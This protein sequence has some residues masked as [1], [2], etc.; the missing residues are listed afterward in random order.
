MS[1]V[2]TRGVAPALGF[3]DVMLTGLAPDGGLYVP[4]AWPE[5]TGSE[6]AGL[7][8]LSYPTLVA[9]ISAPFM[10]GAVAD[11]SGIAEEAY[12]PFERLVPLTELGHG[13]WLLELFWGPTLAFKDYA[14]QLL[15][16]LLDASLAARDSRALLLGATSGDTGSAAIEACRDRS[17]LDI[18]VLHPHG[19]VSDVQR[20]QMTTVA[21]ANVHNVAVRGTFDDCQRLV[22]AMLA[23]S[24]LRR[25]LGVT[26]VNSINWV[27][28]MAQ[29]AYYF[30]AALALGAP[31]REVSFAV[32]TGNF[33]NVFAAYVARQMG[34]PIRRLIIGTN[35]NNVVARFAETGRLS[36]ETVVP[37]ITPAMDI[38]VPS[39]LE[40]LLFDVHDQDG[41]AIRRLMS[42]FAEHGQLDLDPA[43][44]RQLQTFVTGRWFDEPAIRQTMADVFRENALLIDPHSAVGIAAARATER[45]PDIPV[46]C[47]GTAHPAKFPD[48]VEAAT[49]V[50]PPLPEHLAD[51]MERKEIMTVL[52]PDRSAIEAFVHGISR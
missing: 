6:I 28:I 47:V 5:F 22:K 43:R 35:R 29:V 27:R 3:E 31:E 9:A 25:D 30:A 16:R 42:E 1:Y 51:L 14:L 21:A 52:P 38:Q 32:P 13:L 18:V 8:D 36:V 34:L 11:L 37:T 7:R 41:E 46:V 45:E 15:G 44:L 39:N 20:R 50:H 19:R 49:G 23:D 48:A 4:D 33:G 26:S 40:R 17:R 12:A 2:S 24:A 10:D